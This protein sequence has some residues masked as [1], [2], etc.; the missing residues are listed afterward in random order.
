MSDGYDQAV[1]NGIAD[2]IQEDLNG[3]SYKE[4]SEYGFILAVFKFGEPLDGV[5]FMGNV[6]GIDMVKMLRN[7]A[8]MTVPP[9]ARGEGD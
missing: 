9:D 1:L 2:G 3:H 6:S 8:A 5:K 4:D 7:F